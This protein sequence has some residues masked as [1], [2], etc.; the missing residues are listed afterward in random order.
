MTVGSRFFICSVVI[1]IF[2][3]IN[4]AVGPA[5]NK[6]AAVGADYIDCSYYSDQLDEYKKLDPPS[7]DKALLNYEDSVTLC[8]R[9][10]AYYNMEYIAF[11]FDIII[12]FVC[13]LLGLYGLQKEMI[14]KTGLMGMIGGFIGF[15]VTFV[16]VI[17]NGINYTN[18][19]EDSSSIY[20][21]D[22]DTTFAEWDKSQSK[23]KCL[24][25][26]DGLISSIYAKYSDYIKSQYNYNKKL[27]FAF[28]ENAEYKGCDTSSYKYIER[29]GSQEYLSIAIKTYEDN[30]V[31][32]E[33]TKLYY[34]K[35]FKDNKYYDISARFL[36]ALLFGIFEFI[37]FLILT[38]NGYL[39]FKESA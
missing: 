23:Y 14:P 15:V 26:D 13:T 10:K 18:F 6:K 37:C 28:D 8:K 21:F 20:K 25:Y 1:V 36:T 9:W 5:I 33:C 2:T 27:S 32:K 39:L 22:S 16:Y 31:R 7:D 19:Y 24:F 34:K 38:Y 17:L 30:G 35:L 12:G 3:I 29:C 11:I 4:L